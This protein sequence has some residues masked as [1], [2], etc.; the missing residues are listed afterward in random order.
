[1]KI[2]FIAHATF[3]ITLN[4]GRIIVIDPYQG[5]SFQ[6]RFNYP[7]FMT[8]ADVVVITHDHLDHNYTGDIEGES[9]IVRHSAF[10]ITI[11]KTP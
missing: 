11:T 9:V 5:M 1:M 8:R 7:A 4:D 3:R 2:E 6:G 10:D